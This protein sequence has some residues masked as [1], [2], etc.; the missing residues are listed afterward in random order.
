MPDRAE[1]IARCAARWDGPYMRDARRHWTTWVEIHDRLLESIVVPYLRDNWA[2]D[3]AGTCHN[4]PGTLTGY[5]WMMA[6]AFAAQPGALGPLVDFNEPSQSVFLSRGLLI[7]LELCI[8]DIEGRK[9]DGHQFELSLANALA[10][11]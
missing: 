1:Y 11:K 5:C 10:P 6:D 3:L 9:P 2:K 8:R 7:Y 4:R